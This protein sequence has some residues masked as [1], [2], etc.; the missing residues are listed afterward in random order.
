MLPSVA[1]KRCHEL[2]VHF[3]SCQSDLRRKRR[4]QATAA[5]QPAQKQKKRKVWKCGYGECEFEA[6]TQ[7]KL[8]QHKKKE[9]H[10]LQRRKQPQQY[11]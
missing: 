1:S 8:Q 2:L 4:Q 11:L 10:Y 3:D 6:T 7:Y 5:D 9:D